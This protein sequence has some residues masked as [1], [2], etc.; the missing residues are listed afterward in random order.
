MM[1]DTPRHSDNNATAAS[2]PN[3]PGSV[4]VAFPPDKEDVSTLIGYCGKGALRAYFGQNVSMDDY[5]KWLLNK[6]DGLRV[7][8]DEDQQRILLRE[9]CF[10][11]H[12]TTRRYL[13]NALEARAQNSFPVLAEVGQ[14]QSQAQLNDRAK[15]LLG[16][17]PG[18][19]VTQKKHVHRAKFW[20]RDG[21]GTPP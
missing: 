13:S 21:F 10:L 9:G 17:V 4:D 1:T 14:S 2:P 20:S 16:S 19:R 11:S 12:G 15:L 18:A 3:S 7:S 5:N 6:E 8:Y